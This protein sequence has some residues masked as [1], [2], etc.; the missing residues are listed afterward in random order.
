[1]YLTVLACTFCSV[2]ID[3]VQYKYLHVLPS[4]VLEYRVSDSSHYIT[5]W[6]RE[7]QTVNTK[8]IERFLMATNTAPPAIADNLQSRGLKWIVCHG[9][10]K[11]RTLLI[12]TT[13]NSML[14]L[15]VFQCTVL[16][17][18][19]MQYILV[20]CNA[21]QC[22]E[23]LI[24]MCI[25]LLLAAR[26]ET[27]TSPTGAVC[28]IAML[29]NVHCT[30]LVVHW[31]SLLY[32]LHSTER[33]KVLTLYTSSTFCFMSDIRNGEDS[34]RQSNSAGT[35]RWL[36]FQPLRVSWW[37]LV[38]RGWFWLFWLI[39]WIYWLLLHLV[40]CFNTCL[41]LLTFIYTL[42]HLVKLSCS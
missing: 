6:S 19:V 33:T 30:V 29:Q 13:Q 1:M 24:T 4:P 34:G 14:Q 25:F 16:Q 42:L 38:D 31:D 7:M 37:T 15:S 2:L 21:V 40:T 23:V 8:K 11:G 22:S 5:V 36:I 17:C 27:I 26:W 3:T 9:T 41:H 10:E 28:S 39:S 12:R 32:P 18:I 20:Q 35:G